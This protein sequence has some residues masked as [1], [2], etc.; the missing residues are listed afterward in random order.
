MQDRE[1]YEKLI[2]SAEKQPS[3]LRTINTDTHKVETYRQYLNMTPGS[4][5]K[6]RTNGDS[7]S[8]SMRSKNLSYKHG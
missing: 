1:D 2:Q 4:H 7:G 5:I 6:S 8:V 3:K